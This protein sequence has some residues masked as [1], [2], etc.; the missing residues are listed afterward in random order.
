MASSEKTSLRP[1]VSISATVPAFS[2]LSSPTIPAGTASVLLSGHIAAGPVSPVGGSVSITLGGVTQTA[3][4][5]ANG[6]FA[7]TFATGGLPASGYPV[8]YAF[9]GDGANFLAAPDGTGTLTVTQVDPFGAVGQYKPPAGVARPNP[10]DLPKAGDT[11]GVVK[12]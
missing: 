1:S 12:Q 5:D 7:S 2:N 11:V 8:T 3:T 10:A 6:D 9:A 4:V